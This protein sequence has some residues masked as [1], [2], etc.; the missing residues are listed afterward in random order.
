MSSHRAREGRNPGEWCKSK[1]FKSIKNSGT[2]KKDVSTQCISGSSRR[3]KNYQTPKKSKVS[4]SG[5]DSLVTGKMSNN[6]TIN[7]REA[8]PDFNETAS[9]EMFCSGNAKMSTGPKCLDSLQIESNPD[10]PKPSRHG[11]DIA[12]ST[13]HDFT[14]DLI[15][16]SKQK[17][18]RKER[19]PRSRTLNRL[20]GALQSRLSLVDSANSK[21]T[22]SNMKRAKKHF[23]TSVS[24]TVLQILKN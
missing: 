9:L 22:K 7:E 3:V 18:K 20:N 23:Y 4:R 2:R 5:I 24:F 13:E 17:E 12:Y 11:N 1:G 8:L 14:V 15:T 21:S 19:G 16:S 6:S 10:R